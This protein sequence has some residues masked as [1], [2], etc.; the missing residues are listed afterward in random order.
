MAIPIAAIMQLILNH[1]VFN[2]EAREPELSANR[3]YSSRLRYEAQELAE[4][5]RKQ[6]RIK[7]EGSDKRIK[8]IDRVMDEI[9]AVTTDLDSL[10]AKIHPTDEL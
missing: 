5:L 2:R 8:Q 7:I 10:L 9:E 4:D 1:Y 3:D 6:A